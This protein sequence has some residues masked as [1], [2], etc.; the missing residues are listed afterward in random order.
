MPPEFSLETTL[1]QA[2]VQP[3]KSFAEKLR[4]ALSAEPAGEDLLA[5]LQQDYVDEQRL[6]EQLRTHAQRLPNDLR[7]E[8]LGRIAD[9]TAQ[10]AQRLA[11]RILA[12]GGA[13][14]QAPAPDPSAASPALTLWRLL[15]ADLEALTA[16]THRYRAQLGWITDPEVHSLLRQ[17]RADHQQH[18]Q[19]LLDLLARIDSYAQP[20]VN[21]QQHP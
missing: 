18:R 2:L 8:R 21:H 19:A 1:Q 4:R 14:P 5:A 11:E 3:L 10:H 17:L 12:L 15:A 7:R 9:A 13:V 16:L 6:A 20:E